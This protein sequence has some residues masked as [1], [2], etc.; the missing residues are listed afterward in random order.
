MECGQ[1][2]HSWLLE[3]VLVAERISS[4]GESV[5]VER[6]GQNLEPRLS[7]ISMEYD[8]MLRLAGKVSG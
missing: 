2:R 7:V 3:L 5:I 1:S 6:D 8:F 4:S